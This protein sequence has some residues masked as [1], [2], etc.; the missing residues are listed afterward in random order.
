MISLG[1]NTSYPAIRQFTLYQLRSF[2]TKSSWPILM[3]KA[4]LGVRILSLRNRNWT[5]MGKSKSTAVKSRRSLH[6]YSCA[7]CEDLADYNTA[8]PHARHCGKTHQPLHV[9]CML[10]AAVRL[11]SRGALAMQASWSPAMPLTTYLASTAEFSHQKKVDHWS[12]SA[13]LL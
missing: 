2:Y 6:T 10:H 3:L 4:R 1:D 7:F 13:S 9:G 8:L 12:M 11:L 5:V